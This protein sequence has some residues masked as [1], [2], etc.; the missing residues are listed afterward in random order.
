MDNA[1][2]YI[3]NNGMQRND[4]KD[5]IGRYVDKMVWKT[6]EK[7]LDI[8]CGPGDV[9]SD[10]IFQSLKNKIKQMV[11]VDKS[12]QMIE[13]AIKN[14][15][16]S[17]LNFSVLDIDNDNECTIYSNNFTKIFSFFCFQWV[18]KKSDALVNM[19]SMLKNGGEVLIHIL[20]LVP[21]DEM[22][23]HIDAEWI[24]YL[25]DIKCVTTPISSEED[26]KALFI[27][28]GFRIINIESIPRKYKYPDFSSL[29]NAM[30]AVDPLL[31][32]LPSHLKSRYSIH[33]NE[34]ICEAGVA[35]S[36]TGTLTYH[37]L[38]VHAVKD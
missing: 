7:V 36:T 9:T 34:K 38:I 1:E 5:I 27:N 17:N 25:K 30:K 18:Y 33:F 11:G 20:F 14:Y 12:K 8:G 24:N 22:Y 13:Y 28:A 26:A 23:K 19:Y 4:A 35:C 6:N 15:E 3:K 10:I 16:N 37:S 31:S 2:Q 29:L 32:I 21:L